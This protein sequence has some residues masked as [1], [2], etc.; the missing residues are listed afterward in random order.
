MN[1][2]GT[3]AVL[4]L[5]MPKYAYDDAWS[6]GEKSI[7]YL[8][9]H[10]TNYK[11][12]PNTLTEVMIMDSNGQ[13]DRQL[14]NTKTYKSHPSFSHDSKRIVFLS[15]EKDGCPVRR[16]QGISCCFLFQKFTELLI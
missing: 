16:P 3:E 2:D 14:T 11:T 9:S 12:D 7:V 5:R 15:E 13:N 8:S 6:Y 4:V 1:V 10:M